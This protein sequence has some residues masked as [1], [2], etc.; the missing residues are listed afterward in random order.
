[1]VQFQRITH[2]FA[3][4]IRVLDTTLRDGEQTPGVKFSQQAKVE[5]VRA[6]KKL[7]VDII[8]AGSAI[9]GKEERKA[10]AAVCAE[11]GDNRMVSSFARARLEDV[12]AVLE[13]GA[14]RVSLVFPASDLHI[15]HKFRTSYRNEAIGRILKVVEKHECRC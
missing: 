9:N 11:L 5:I 14:G 8:E 10:I 7:G 3:Q 12:N 6:L 2:T 4:K 13:A 15:K 1:M